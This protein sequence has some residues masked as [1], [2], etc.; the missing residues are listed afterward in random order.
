MCSR[1]RTY[2][3]TCK[4][5]YTHACMHVWACTWTHVCACLMHWMSHYSAH[6]H[7][8]QF[9]RGFVTYVRIRVYACAGTWA[10]TDVHDHMRMHACARKHACLR[11]RWGAPVHARVHACKR[12]CVLHVHAYLHEKFFWCPPNYLLCMTP[13]SLGLPLVTG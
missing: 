4:R 2:A 3:C 1:V 12:A 9:V 7:A 10:L 8:H 11:T 6:A 13:L 5:T